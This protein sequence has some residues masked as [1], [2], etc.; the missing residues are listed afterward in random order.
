M[1][2]HSRIALSVVVALL[3]IPAA[4]TAKGDHGHHCEKCGNSNNACGMVEKTVLC[5]VKVI[6]T[7]VKPRVTTECKIIEEKYTA[8]RVVP[9][10]RT[11][12][13][14]CCYLLD[15]VKSKEI[16][17]QSCALVDVNVVSEKN[18]QVPQYELVEKCSEKQVCTE[19]GPACV[20]EC[21]VEEIARMHADV[22]VEERC[23]KQLLIHKTT[24]EIF[25]CV[26]TP[27]KHTIEC[28]EE[29]IYKLEPVEKTRKVKVN[30][31]KIEYVPYEV[32]VVK[33]LPKKILTCEECTPHRR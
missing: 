32:E 20:E 24:K 18:V 6:E 22:C 12:T 3:S 31:P 29:T 23:E 13:K 4:Q 10:K 28:A 8:Y 17:E 19:C 16:V 33:M 5:P 27:K 25:Y 15:E 7:R 2:A 26:K 1:L 9:E 30:V 11:I 21:C 14:D